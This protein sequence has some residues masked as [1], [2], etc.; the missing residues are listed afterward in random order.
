MAL[1]F[2]AVE[3]FGANIPGLDPG[4]PALPSQPLSSQPLAAAA[5]GCGEAAACRR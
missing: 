5:L 2:P 4:S 1:L 3:P